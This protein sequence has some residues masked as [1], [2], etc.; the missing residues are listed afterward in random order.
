MTIRV[1]SIYPL[2]NKLES[3]IAENRLI[4][5]TKTHLNGS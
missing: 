5:I 2:L 1:I 4:N 3:E